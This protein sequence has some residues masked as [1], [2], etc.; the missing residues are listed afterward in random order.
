MSLLCKILTIGYSNVDFNTFLSK[1]KRVNIKTIFD[2]RSIPYSKYTPQ[3]NRE[4]IKKELYKNN[5]CYIYVG[6]MIGGWPKKEEYY[7]DNI[8]DYTKMI[9]DE[10]FNK[11]LEYIIN[12]SKKNNIAL[13]CSEHNPFTCHRFLLISRE[14]IRRGFDVNHVMKDGHI[15]SHHAVELDMINSLTKKEKKIIMETDDKLKATYWCKN[16]RHGH[17]RK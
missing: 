1:I 11:G 13:A 7:T 12:E 2:V 8:A 17:K 3:F 4:N 15:K 14:L 16:R 5:V 9:N 6:D 10:S